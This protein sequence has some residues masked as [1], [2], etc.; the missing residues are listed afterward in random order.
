M[1]KVKAL[2]LS[3]QLRHINPLDKMQSKF[4]QYHYS[5]IIVTIILVSTWTRKTDYTPI[6]HNLIIQ[7][8][9]GFIFKKFLVVHLYKTKLWAYTKMS[10]S[11]CCADQNRSQSA[12]WNSLQ[13]LEIFWWS[14]PARHIS[15][16]LVDSTWIKFRLLF[17]HSRWAINRC[18]PRL[19]RSKDDTS[20][21]TRPIIIGMVY[22]GNDYYI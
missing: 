3:F 4:D 5:L 22:I 10:K 7:M 16:Q 21:Q 13:T 11:L 18:K 6:C 15:K 14:Y 8:I 12:K 2:S 9:S 1:L 19:I 17:H 20:L